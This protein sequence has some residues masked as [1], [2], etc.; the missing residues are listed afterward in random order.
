MSPGGAQWGGLWPS[1]SFPLFS[2]VSAPLRPPLVTKLTSPCT[3]MKNSRHR[4]GYWRQVSPLATA[5]RQLL[6]YLVSSLQKP[7]DRLLPIPFCRAGKL[8]LGE[9]ESHGQSSRG[10]DKALS[11]TSVNICAADRIGNTEVMEGFQLWGTSE[12]SGVQLRGKGGLSI[13]TTL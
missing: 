3:Q 5:H 12:L 8:W 2:S 13:R 9:V 10:S 6:G 4:A 11:E 1:Y 7:C